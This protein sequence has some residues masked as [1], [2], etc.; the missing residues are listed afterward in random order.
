VART[1][2]I[3]DGEVVNEYV[4]RALPSLSPALLLQATRMARRSTFA[5]GETI[6][7]QG[8]PGD[9]LYIVTK[10]TAEVTLRRPS[11]T[12]VVADRMQPGQYFGEI[13]LYNSSRTAATV[14]AIPE[15][16]VEALTLDRSVFQRL[17]DESQDFR[18][19]MKSVVQV[20]TAHNESVVEG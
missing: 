18:E 6:I 3:V 13:S 1:V 8:C 10:G 12:D 5:P 7:Q 16:P 11:G 20:R 9:Q 14:R 15:A 2:L 17:M 4:A 19:A